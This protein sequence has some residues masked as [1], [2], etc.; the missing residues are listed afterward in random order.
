MNKENCSLKLVDEIILCCGMLFAVLCTVAKFVLMQWRPL[1][2]VE[3]PCARNNFR[4]NLVNVLF[5]VLCDREVTDEGV[6]FF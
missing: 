2:S 4:Q 5:L 3:I 6:V 1:H